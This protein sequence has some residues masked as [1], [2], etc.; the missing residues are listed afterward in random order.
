MASSAMVNF[1]LII[2]TWF[3]GSWL[4]LCSGGSC[5][6]VCLEGIAVNHQHATIPEAPA[7]VPLAWHV[8]CLLHREQILQE[9]A[10]PPSQ[11]LV[12]WLCSQEAEFHV[13]P[14]PW[15]QWQ[16]ELQAGTQPAG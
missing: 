12:Y 8:L 11:L 6:S 9:K 16:A 3:Y 1:Y 15:R 5:S 4:L 2:E 13:L 7:F 10:F 14:S